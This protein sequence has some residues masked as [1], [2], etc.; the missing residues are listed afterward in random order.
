MPSSSR[1]PYSQSSRLPYPASNVAPAMASPITVNSHRN[2]TLVHRGFYD[3]LSLV[4]G[5][6]GVGVGTRRGKVNDM[7]PHD[8]L[9][10]GQ[11]YEDIGMGGPPPAPPPGGIYP[12]NRSC[13]IATYPSLPKASG[14]L[15]HLVHASDADQAEA[16]LSRWGPDGIGKLGNPNWAQ[17]IKTQ[18]RSKQ[19]E[20]AVAEVMHAMDATPSTSSASALVLRVVNGMST[21]T[22]TT[23]TVAPST[24]GAEKTYSR[25]ANSNSRLGLSPPLETQHEHSGEESTDA[26]AGHT[27][28]GSEITIKG[29]SIVPHPPKQAQATVSPDLGQVEMV[30]SPLVRREGVGIGHPI[31][32]RSPGNPPQPRSPG[33]IAVPPRSP[34]RPM[35]PRPPGDSSAVPYSPAQSVPYSPT[36]PATPYTPQHTPWLPTTPPKPDFAPATPPK[37]FPPPTPPKRAD[38]GYPISPKRDITPV[39]PKREFQPATMPLKRSTSRPLPIPAGGAI[40]APED[41]LA[42]FANE[43]MRGVNGGASTY[44]LSSLSLAPSTLTDMPRGPIPIPGLPGSPPKSGLPGSPGTPGTIRIHPEGTPLPAPTPGAWGAT[45]I[46]EDAEIAN[47][48][49]TNSGGI[50]VPRGF[51][52]S[53][54]GGT[55]DKWAT[56]PNVN[57]QY[58]HLIIGFVIL[59]YS[60][61]HWGSIKS[62]H[63]YPAPSKLFRPSLTTLDKAVSAKIYFENV[64]FPLLRLPPSREQRRLAMEAEMEQ[65]N[66][67]Q[68]MRTQLRA[69]WRANETAYLR[70]RRRRVDQ[71]SFVK[72][73]TIGHGAFGVVSLVKEKDTGELYAMK[74]MRKVDML[75]KGQEGHV[76]AERDVLK[77]AALV[78]SP[79][80]ADWIV[81]LFYSFQ[82][83]D[84]LYLVLE[85]MGGGDLLN[86]LIEKD[87]FEEDFA[88][89]YIAEMILA[90]EQCHKQGFIHRDIKPDNF[91]FDPNGHI[92]LS[93]FGLATD[94]HWAH[95][96]SY[97]EQQ[98]RDLL[99]KHGIDLED[100][101]TR[102]HKNRRMDKFEADRV[103]G[104]EGVF[105]WR[106][107][108]RKKLAYSVCGTNSYMSPEV[109]RG[110]GYSF[111][112]D[113]WS[114]GV[115]MFECLYGYPPFVSNSRHVTRQK[116][117]NWRTSLRFPPRPKIS[118]EG[119]DLMARLLCEP[120]D[121]IGAQGGL[122]PGMNRRSGFLGGS[123][124]G[125]DDIKAHPWFRDIDFA[126][127]HEQ[128][129]PFRPELQRPDDTKHFD[130][131]I[132]PEPLAPANGAPPDATR[133]P[134]LRHKVHGAHILETRK[135]F[136]FAGF[137]HKSP[138]KISYTTIDAILKPFEDNDAKRVPAAH[139]GDDE[140]RGRST[141]R[142]QETVGR[143]RAISM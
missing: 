1:L 42:M 111:S 96:T 81:R 60:L 39:T 52:N 76:R 73:K 122:P 37:D 4:P 47:S 13:C 88:K 51:T 105:T 137:T 139:G 61:P 142:E 2:S 14:I 59:T 70:E 90:I 74:Q 118:R 6:A 120:E 112:C 33:R 135:A 45:A 34:D 131:E 71:R 101:E 91:L 132:A 53:I 119:V 32:P 56:G 89:F 128:E 21:S 102:T 121:R 108:N 55:G 18:I 114:L 46:K 9:V 41:P 54:I 127:I 82:D 62:N 97:Y 109:I 11:R 80:G 116:I 44:P 113:W 92:K 19:Q 36:Q 43:L 28:E 65:L 110:Q 31:G 27:S 17:P 24:P 78:S 49:G 126:R 140:Q 106:E 98:R 124:D 99:H 136:A 143:G 86:L 8:E 22:L 107:K 40:G 20:R 30:A 63:S 5:T 100:G 130:T 67:P 84:H 125:A 77:G 141:L 103:M 123:L 94:L 26:K 69:R 10:P 93:D 16:L 48:P 35:G 57:R 12:F 95:D 129:A 79:T 133:D 115:I 64:Y 7:W 138:R 83:Q 58:Y 50:G 68:H 75:R 72:L 23:S 15:S 25:L 117:L 3:L 85:F 66:I 38:L 104:G 87:I 134:M 29:R